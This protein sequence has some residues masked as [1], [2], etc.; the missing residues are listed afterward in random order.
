MASLIYDSRKEI[1][2]EALHKAENAVFFDDR[3]NYADAIRAYGSSCALLGQVMRTT[4]KSV[5]RATVET[6]RTSYI[7]R[8]YELQGSLGPMSPRF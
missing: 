8:I 6:I 5:D 3:G 4:L 2:S 1:L 7:K